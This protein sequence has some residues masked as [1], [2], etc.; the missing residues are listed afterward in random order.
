MACPL[1]VG[2][3]AG[4]GSPRNLIVPCAGA[5]T[6]EAGYRRGDFGPGLR[7]S[8]LKGDLFSGAGA[9]VKAPVEQPQRLCP[10]SA[11]HWPRVG[12][13]SRHEKGGLERE[14]RL[15]EQPLWGRRSASP[16]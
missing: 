5:A 14:A 9:A 13:E 6:P 1:E 7:S 2:S 10:C 16:W 4:L 11:S 3:R 15:C 12:F 8:G